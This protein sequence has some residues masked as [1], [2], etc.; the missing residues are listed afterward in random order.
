M[1]RSIQAGIV[2]TVLA[3]VIALFLPLPDAL[4]FIP[5]FLGAI[6][7]VYIFRLAAVKD[8]LVAAF[9]TYIFQEGI[10]STVGLVTLYVSNE[11]YS[12]SNIDI[13]LALSP[14]VS[15]ISALISGYL[16]VQ[17]VKRMKQPQE[18]PPSLPPPL[19]PV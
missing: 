17:L 8:G 12:I 11:P 9:M 16:G 7:G 2:G 3:I 14:I 15:A 4:G 10:L 5:P 13:W 18:V 6:L 1:D 19:P